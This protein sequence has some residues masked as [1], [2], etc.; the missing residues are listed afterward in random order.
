MVM[1]DFTNTDM[2]KLYFK[3]I[4][5]NLADG[6]HE[7][8]MEMQ[9]IPIGAYWLE[10]DEEL[11]EMKK[12]NWVRPCYGLALDFLFFFLDI[13]VIVDVSNASGKREYYSKVLAMDSSGEIKGS[14]ITYPI[15]DYEKAFECGLE[16]AIK[17]AKGEI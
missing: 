7:L 6:L 4:P 8:G 14:S 1:K 16:D 5:W 3:Q 17:M 11:K 2:D 13:F 9:N 15:E 10:E 12:R